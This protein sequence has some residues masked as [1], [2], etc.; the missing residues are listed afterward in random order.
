MLALRPLTARLG[1]RDMEPTH[2]DTI[3]GYVLMLG[4]GVLEVHRCATMWTA[5]PATLFGWSV[6]P[7]V[8]I[9]KGAA[10]GRRGPAGEVSHCGIAS[11]HGKKNPARG[12]STHSMRKQ[13]GCSGISAARSRTASTRV[14]NSAVTL[15]ARSV[16][17]QAFATR[18]FQSSSLATTS[19]SSTTSRPSPTGTTRP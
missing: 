1:R 11:D 4:Q 19:R 12:G 15:S 10:R 16:T 3:D 5:L 14:D 18:R 6:P 17:L 8:R 7:K 13:R 9:V 2:R